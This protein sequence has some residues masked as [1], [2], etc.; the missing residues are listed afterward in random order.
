MDARDGVETRRLGSPRRRRKYQGGEDRDQGTS[1]IPVRSA[2]VT[3]D[4]T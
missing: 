4:F 3:K 2:A 1:A